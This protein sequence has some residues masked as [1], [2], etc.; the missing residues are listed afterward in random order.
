MPVSRMND[1]GLDWIGLKNPIVC[2]C[3]RPI[4][5]ILLV[6]A[7]IVFDCV[8]SVFNKEYDDDDDDDDGVTLK[9]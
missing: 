1:V 7:C 5:L 6:I 4:L 3:I 8:L 2:N 9:S